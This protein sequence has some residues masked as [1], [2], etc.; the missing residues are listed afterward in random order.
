MARLLCV[1]EQGGQLGHLNSLKLPIELA[2]EM[3]HEV[4]LAARELRNVKTVLGDLP[5]TVLQAPFKQNIA[6]TGQAPSLSFTHLIARQCFSSADELSALSSAWRSIFDAVQP[7][8]V[9]IEHSPTALVSALP[10]GFQ[11]ILMGQG[12]SLPPEPGDIHAPFAPFPTTPVTKEIVAALCKDD[13]HLL[14]MVNSVLDKAGVLPLGR[15]FDIYAQAHTTLCMTWPA[16]DPFGPRATLQYLGGQPL[17]VARAPVWP[18][19]DGVRVFAYLQLF[20]A[21]EQLLNDLQASGLRALLCVR[22]APPALVN[23]YCKGRVQITNDMVDMR[24]VTAE[25]EW[26]ISHA[27][28]STVATVALAGLPQ[29]LIPRQQEQL[30]LSLKLVGQGS[31]IAVFQDQAGFSNALDAM[32]TM[33]TLK[34]RAAQLKSEMSVHNFTPRADLVRNVLLHHLPP[35]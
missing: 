13:E 30:F 25:A 5:V 7:H 29:L 33:P 31:A 12:F 32:R 19:G 8:A 20:P 26:V 9:L 16:L 27:N 6:N 34:A 3:G 17:S 2:L 1:W 22:D 21:L 35:L 11:K 10:Y 28:H 15:L 23:A 24:R 4:F 14:A 18:Q